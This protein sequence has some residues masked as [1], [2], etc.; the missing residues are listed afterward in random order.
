MNFA[1]ALPGKCNEIAHQF[2]L[3]RSKSV[4]FFW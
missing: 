4:L 3:V 2:V 1:G